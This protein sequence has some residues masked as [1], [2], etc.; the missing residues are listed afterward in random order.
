M[1]DE[2]MPDL[3]D[4]LTFADDVNGAYTWF[5]DHILPQI[6]GRI[7]WKLH[8]PKKFISKVATPSDEAFAILLM[9]NSYDLWKA[10]FNT[11]KHEPKHTG[12]GGA[13]IPEAK[14]SKNGGGTAK[15]KG[16]SNEGMNRFNEIR[17][18]IITIRKSPAGQRFQEKY[19]QKQQEEENRRLGKKK[20]K[21]GD[22]E[23]RP[24]I[25]MEAD[26]DL[27]DS[28]EA[29]KGGGIWVN[30]LLVTQMAEA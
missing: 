17:S 3:E 10:T 14:Y 27:S 5:C 2:T 29:E 23:L 19:L 1:R 28:D 20:R 22:S 21:T 9:E 24:T 8:T 13:N 12:E 16:W 4:I 7:H 25:E 30:G 6:T 11:K 15:F 26:E 18:E